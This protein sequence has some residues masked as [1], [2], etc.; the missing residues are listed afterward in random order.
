MLKQRELLLRSLKTVWQ[1]MTKLAAE[2]FSCT[3]SPML[4]EFVP[5]IMELMQYNMNRESNIR[6]QRR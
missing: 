5:V 6:Y 1:P 3:M 4:F 2:K